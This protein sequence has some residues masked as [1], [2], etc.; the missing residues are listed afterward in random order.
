MFDLSVLKSRTDQPR[1][2][3][4]STSPRPRSGTD[5]M[6]PDAVCGPPLKEMY[7]GVDALPQPLECLVP[8]P[9][10]GKRMACRNSHGASS[11]SA[12]YFYV[13]HTEKNIQTIQAITRRKETSY[14][15][16]I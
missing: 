11:R 13:K 12:K 9:P 8:D 15:T 7:S 16:C 1:V 4:P 14:A 6:P 5:G 2:G 10:S 3:C